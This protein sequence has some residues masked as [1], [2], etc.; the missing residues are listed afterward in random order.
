[1]LG[2]HAL[3]AWSKTQ[4]VIA[5]SFAESEVSAIVRASIEALGLLTFF[6]DVGMAI[7]IPEYTL[8]P[9]RPRASLNAKAW[10][11]FVLLK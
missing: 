2:T 1:M 11:R 6:K 3:K 5:K 9:S 7:L 8:T 4:S 10:V